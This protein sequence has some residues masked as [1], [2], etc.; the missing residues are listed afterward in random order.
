VTVVTNDGSFPFDYTLS[1][2]ENFLTIT[3]SG[4]ETI[5]STTLDYALGFSALQQVRI[6]GIAGGVVVPEPGMLAL[7]TSLGLAGSLLLP[8]RLR[9]R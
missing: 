1:N 8:R 3:T 6:S 9:R 5:N 4:G 2:G 7:A